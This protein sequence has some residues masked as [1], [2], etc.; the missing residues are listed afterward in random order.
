M[1]VHYCHGV[2]GK[3]K[4][5]LFVRSTWLVWMYSILVKQINSREVDLIIKFNNIL[6][7]NYINNYFSFY[8]HNPYPCDGKGRQADRQNDPGSHWSVCERPETPAWGCAG[9]DLWRHG[10]RHQQVKPCSVGVCGPVGATWCSFN[11]I[12]RL[13][14]CQQPKRSSLKTWDTNKRCLQRL[15]NTKIQF[16]WNTVINVGSIELRV[17]LHMHLQTNHSSD[18]A[19][20][21]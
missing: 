11:Y 10:V 21:Q 15:H 8:S 1:V 17:T 16:Y 4:L 19:C 6:V 3:K 5:W 20:L 7:I 14:E 9:R 12:W 18:T 2:T 13:A